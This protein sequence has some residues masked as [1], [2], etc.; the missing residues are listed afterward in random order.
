[1]G[2]D[3]HIIADVQQIDADVYAAAARAEAD[4]LLRHDL[5]HAVWSTGAVNAPGISDL[6]LIVVF[7][8]AFV[9]EACPVSLKMDLLAASDR[10]VRI[11]PC[12]GVANSQFG[13]LPWMFV[14][15]TLELV[16]GRAGR[17]GALSDDDAALVA[18]CAVV[19]TGVHKLCALYDLARARALPARFALIL[20]NS[21]AFTSGL[22][23][24]LGA[25]RSGFIDDVR[26][27]RS[28]WLRMSEAER[29]ARMSSLVGHAPAVV[30]EALD[31]ASEIVLRSLDCQSESLG[32]SLEV[33]LDGG[34]RLSSCFG[35]NGASV[36]AS[37]STH[38]RTVNVSTGAGLVFAMHRALVARNERELAA[39]S[40]RIILDWDA[41]DILGEI[42]LR[43]G[44]PMSRRC[45]I[46]KKYTD[47]QRPLR[48]VVLP[49]HPMAYWGD[50]SPTLLARARLRIM[51][52][53][54]Q[55]TRSFQSG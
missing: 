30:E 54:A 40:R 53:L 34:W 31:Y 4:K 9:P 39:L 28:R 23:A 26:D 11:H 37:V 19:E 50:R 5:V 24:D 13:D 7:S 41:R 8:D 49:F 17:C 43:D 2:E 46:L 32:G 6:D 52:I 33:Q 25:P 35:G 27:A 15:K 36:R 29:S 3:M 18:A 12:F 48:G 51:S 1:M 45:E 20:L 42:D 47:W 38:E 10:R 55:S 22:C 14:H 44:H 16:G 21:V